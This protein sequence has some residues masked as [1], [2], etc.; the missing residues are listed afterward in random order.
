VAQVA[1][2]TLFDF[3]MFLIFWDNGS[4][5]VWDTQQILVE[6]N[7]SECKWA[8]RFVMGII[9]M[10]HLSEAFHW[11]VLDQAMDLNCLISIHGVPKTSSLQP[12]IV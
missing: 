9:A 7:A 3:P 6:P 1:F 2:P 5:L 8:K 12:R 10:P 4:G 11:L